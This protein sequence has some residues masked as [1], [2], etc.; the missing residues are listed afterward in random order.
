M[1]AV[2]VWRDVTPEVF[3]QQIRPTGL[4]AVL[5]GVVADWPIVGVAQAGGAAAIDYLATM[6]TGEPVPVVRAPTR[7]QGRLHY[8]DALKG[9]NFARGAAP[10]DAF[11]K[12]LHVEAAKATPDVL[13]VQGVIAPRHLPG[14]AETHPLAL[15]PETATPRLWIGT[16]AKVATHNDP[17]E[18][19]AC[20]AAGHRRFTLFSPDQIGDLYMGPFHP[21]PAGTPISMAH[22]T[23]PDF[24]RFPRFAAA[25]DAALVAELEPGDAI[26][27]PY[28][29]Y[30]HVEA[31]DGLNVLVN[32]WWDE[33]R[34]DV[35]SPWDAMMHG[36]MTLRTLPADQRRA[37][38]AMFEQYVFLEN[39]DPAAHLPPHAHGVLS[40]TTPQDIV[41]MRRALI[42]NLRRQ[43]EER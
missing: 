33:A 39:G 20:V 34:T 22:V 10:L 24:E 31:L 2:S 28:Q 26:Y 14:F 27:I 40:A 16:A 7:V 6:A 17:S 15:V 1:P 19:I 21:T 38:K 8:D 9:M 4:P 43:D 13:C 36:M 29:W 35:G 25:L 37:W 18:N 32:Y 5:K 11:L 3:R 41:Q 12:A 30:H 23:A 42:A